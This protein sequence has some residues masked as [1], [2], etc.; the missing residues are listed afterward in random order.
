MS[1]GGVPLTSAPC[2]RLLVRARA[3][4]DRGA[5][6]SERESADDARVALGVAAQLESFCGARLRATGAW[7]DDEIRR[8]A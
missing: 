3:Y 2:D 4:A 1:I 5:V 6:L 7:R 8:T